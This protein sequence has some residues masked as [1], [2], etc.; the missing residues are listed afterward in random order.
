MSIDPATAAVQRE[1]LWFESSADGLA[2]LMKA[3]AETGT[4]TRPAYWQAKNMR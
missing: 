3:D 1:A 4:G 2:P